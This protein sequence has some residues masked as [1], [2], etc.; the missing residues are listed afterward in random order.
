[1]ALGEL[2]L[3]RLD[4]FALVTSID[5][6]QRAG[7]QPRRITF[8]SGRGPQDALSQMGAGT[9]RVALRRQR[10]TCSVENPLQKRGDFWVV[11]GVGLRHLGPVPIEID[12]EVRFLQWGRAGHALES[13][14]GAL[15]RPHVP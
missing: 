1:M 14:Q 15:E 13:R 6:L 8:S 11:Y 10:G 5:A 3:T 4:K 12:T 9:L 7:A 2:K